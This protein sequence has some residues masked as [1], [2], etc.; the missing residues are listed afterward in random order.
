MGISAPSQGSLVNLYRGAMIGQTLSKNIGTEQ[1]EGGDIQQA[2]RGTLLQTAVASGKIK[3]NSLSSQ[4][5]GLLSQTVGSEGITH[6]PT[7]QRNGGGGLLGI[8]GTPV[9]IFTNTVGDLVNALTSLPAGLEQLGKSAYKTAQETTPFPH[10][11]IAGPDLL[12]LGKDIGKS[13]I[14]DFT[15]FNPMHPLYPALDLAT[16]VSG[17]ASGAARLGSLASRATE[18]AEAGSAAAR[19]GEL[20]QRISTRL[21]GLKRPDI[22]ISQEAANAAKLSSPSIPISNYSVSPFRRLMVEKPIERLTT[23]KLGRLSSSQVPLLPG[24][25]SLADLRAN[26]HIRKVTNVARGRA[27]AGATAATIAASKPLNDALKALGDESS[28]GREALEKFTALV[29]HRQLAVDN[30]TPE[31]RLE[32]LD[33]YRQRVLATGTPYVEGM[34]MQTEEVKAI[35]KYYRDLTASSR[36]RDFFSHPTSAMMNVKDAWDKALIDT[37]RTMNIDP[38]EILQRSLGPA[39]HIRDL[40]PEELL[41]EQPENV[42]RSMGF[43]I[44]AKE[45]EDALRASQGEWTP[46]VTL[47]DKL[48]N[49]LPQSIPLAERQD[50]V[51]RAIESLR[52]DV[53]GEHTPQELLRNGDLTRYIPGQNL[54]QKIASE[55]PK[56]GVPTT[57]AEPFASGGLTNYFPL[58]TAYKTQKVFKDRGR[59]GQAMN[60]LKGKETGVS[61]KNFRRENLARVLN[62]NR[63]GVEPFSSFMEEADLSAF[64]AG[65]DRRDPQLLFK[66]IQQREKLIAHRMINEP[67]IRKLSLK[68]AEGEVASFGTQADLENALGSTEAAK[69]WVLTSP[70]V[71]Q[72]LVQSESNAG[73]EIAN[74]IKKDGTIDSAAADRIISE[75][76]VQYVRDLA[77]SVVVNG[78]KQIAMPASWMDNL[79]KQARVADSGNKVG[80][81]WQ[82]FINKWRTAVLA[83]M[84]SWLLRTSLGHGVILFLSGVWNP[85]HYIK[86]MQYFGNGFK[87]PFSEDTRA[88]KGLGRPVPA[89]VD[90]GSPHEDFGIIAHRLNVKSPIAPAIT[91]GVHKIAN[92][93]RRAAFISTLNK[94]TKQHFAELRETFQFPHG[95]R[96]TDNLD[97]II[98]DHP[99]WVHHALNELDKVSYTFG[100]MAPWERR[101]AKNVLPF[102][103][104]YKFVSKFVWNLPLTYPGRTLALTRIGEIGQSN[105]DLLGPM[106]DWLRASLMFDT[107]NLA[108]V[109]Y[110]S[111]LG[112]NPLG[113]VANPENGIQGLVS[114]GQM[115]PLIQAGLEGMG[116]NTMT[117][118][119]ENVDPSSGIEEVNGVYV[120][121]H[122]GKEYDSVAEASL[123]AS[124]ERVVGGLMRSFPELRIAELGATKGKNVYPES[125]P[126]IN[127]KTIPPASPA[128]V[129]NVS[130]LGLLA[131]Y[132][133]VAPKTYN[134][135]KYQANLLMDLKRGITQQRKAIRKEGAIK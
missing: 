95:L 92:F 45:V 26:Y 131:M 17:G 65:V 111:M 76:G 79:I 48:A 22:P 88:V 106:P 14:S 72:T 64:K 82:A 123:G 128:S 126:L 40:S 1:A 114:L 13:T 118:G 27:A 54:S 44:Q 39:A 133:G 63:L 35:R 16:L 104:W 11:E 5:Q 105:Q 10:S 100:Q 80:H 121:T 36:F 86:A 18:A 58:E 28:N 56:L 120:N 59:V 23:S 41:R 93:Q 108:D 127:E 25:K 2:V 73:L 103:G 110:M 71:I 87:M 83:Y 8:L 46:E 75:S 99:E 74:L 84:P 51:K 115:S 53:S 122:T 125:I 117:G 102:W 96:N 130:P 70:K 57:V 81:V 78:D 33:E 132:G 89:G 15:H 4:D 91:H 116:Y 30:L 31:K 19:V 55:L 42:Q 94:I 68:T 9:H 113:D 3:P 50:L 37:Q 90:Q 38:Q 129:K 124:I 97:A 77:D 49:F 12:S 34:P 85:V 101:L 52:A 60:K 61:L 67:L 20:G 112:L 62:A 7:V 24:D 32:I 98:H 21:A 69:K 135:Q 107:H 119:L 47:D 134:L 66:H 29:T 43:A 6:L 109:H